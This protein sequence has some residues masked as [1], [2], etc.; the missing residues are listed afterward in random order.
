MRKILILGAEGYLGSLLVPYLS[1]NN[2]LIGVD[3]CFFGMNNSRKIRNYKLLNIDYKK[4]PTKFFKQFDYIVDLVNISND[5]ASELNVGFTTQTNY[6]NKV[7]LL[8]KIKKNKNIKRYI[9]MSS[10]SV[11]GKNSNLVTEKSKANPISLYSKLCFKF[12]KYLKKNT[13]TKHTILRLGTLYGWSKRMRYDLAINKIIRDMIFAKKVEILG[14]TQ[15]RFFCFNEFACDI[16]NK[17]LSDNSNKYMNKTY[18]IGV[19]NTNIIS[20]K[21]KILKLTKLKDVTFIHEKHSIDERS[22]KVSL[23]SLK[24]LLSKKI[25]LNNYVNKSI[26]KTFN[27]IKKDRSPYDK[28]KITLNVYKDF[29]MGKNV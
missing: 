21:N 9:Y 14:G 2:K 7:K 18:N 4:L 13:T 28:D 6:T 24:K 5:P 25:N 15:F 16:I 10:C 11:Y 23:N 17:I 27:D 22:Y 29:L 20:L 1:K 19:F 12:E 8:E 3:R 26:L